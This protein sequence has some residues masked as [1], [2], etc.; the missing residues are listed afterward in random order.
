MSE[1]EPMATIGAKHPRNIL[2]GQYG[3]PTHPVMVTIPIG[4]WTASVIFDIVGLAGHDEPA[5]AQGATWLVGIGIIGAL[6]AAI[7]GLLDLSVIPRRTKAFATG[8]THMS[9]N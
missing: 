2:A 5:F 7:F 9:L 8:L 1:D 4:A 3:H 6:A